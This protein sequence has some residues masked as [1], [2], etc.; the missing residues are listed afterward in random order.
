[1]SLREYTKKR[2]FTQT[3]EPEG[4]IGTDTGALRFVVQRHQASRL[5]YDFRLEMDGVLKSWAVPKGPSLDPHDKRL[6]IMVEDHPYSYRNFEGVIPEGNYGAGTVSIWDEGTYHAVNITD[7][8]N[9]EKILL[10][11]LEKGT[12]TF[13]LHG[14]KLR[15][16]WA[17][18][19]THGMGKNAWLL[20][21]HQDEYAV[22]GYDSEAHLP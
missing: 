16:T 6:A 18:V 21:K 22:A 8:T 1:M 20:I 19:K 5:H 15:G 11:E 4:I 10:A 3:S 14:R 9:S 2:D 13:V 7:R 17:L 12:I